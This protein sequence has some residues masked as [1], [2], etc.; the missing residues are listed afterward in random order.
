MNKILNNGLMLLVAGAFV[1]SCADYNDT[2]GFTAQ[3]DPSYDLPYAD[4]DAVKSYINKAEY[5]NMRVDAAIKLTDFNKQALDHA[6]AITN[7]NGV[8]F[9][10]SFMPSAYVSKK[11]RLWHSRHRYLRG[12]PHR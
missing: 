2:D 10:N 7:F 11:R 3:P 12:Y 5:P 9:G 1:V 4:L 8:A 6:A